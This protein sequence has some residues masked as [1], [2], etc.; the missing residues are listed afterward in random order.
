MHQ[1]V[2][3]LR[4]YLRRVTGELRTTRQMLAQAHE[5]IAIVPKTRKSLND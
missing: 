5:P 4:N 1:E 3:R 2:E